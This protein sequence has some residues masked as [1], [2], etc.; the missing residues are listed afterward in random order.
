MSGYNYPVC[1][2]GCLTWP[3]YP[4][5][6]RSSHRQVTE[7][8]HLSLNSVVPHFFPS[9]HLPGTSS[10]MKDIS[11]LILAPTLHPR[12]TDLSLG[13]GKNFLLGRVAPRG[14]LLPKSNELP[15][16]GCD[17]SDWEPILSSILCTCSGCTSFTQT[18]VTAP[19]A[20]SP[21]LGLS[22]SVSPHSNHGDLSETPAESG[23]F[24]RLPSRDNPKPPF[25]IQALQDLV[26]VPTHPFTMLH[27]P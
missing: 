25:Y 7:P 9:F 12:K 26:P 23:L 13:L 3:G 1:P 24:L 5:G 6:R 2:A 27:P 4:G 17:R 19:L 20:V 18:L 21:P 8:L 15:V 11:F 14:G 22:Q 16:S 10:T